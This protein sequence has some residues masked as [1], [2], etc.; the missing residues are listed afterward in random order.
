MSAR[1]HSARPRS[2]EKL[3]PDVSK[4]VAFEYLDFGALEPH[5]TAI[6]RLD[7]RKRNVAVKNRLEDGGVKERPHR[8]LRHDHRGRSKA[9]PAQVTRSI[10]ENPRWL[11]R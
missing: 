4:H 10:E 3:P 8:S 2:V 6:V 7:C 5:A 1:S 9:M 11:G